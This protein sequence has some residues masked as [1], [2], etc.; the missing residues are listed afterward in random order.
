MNHSNQIGDLRALNDHRR[1]APSSVADGSRS[2]A[3]VM[4]LYRRQ[5]AH[6]DARAA[7]AH[8]MAER[9]CAAVH[10]DIG[11]VEPEQ[12][13]STHRPTGAAASEQRAN[14]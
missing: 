13:L 12:G 8:R 14:R 4:R 3:G 5:Q 1:A 7:R 6:D 10:V 9:H 2:N 11:A